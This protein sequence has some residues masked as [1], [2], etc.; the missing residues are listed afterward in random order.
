MEYLPQP[1]KIHIYLCKCILRIGFVVWRLKNLLIFPP[2]TFLHYHTKQTYT[3]RF[4]NQILLI[5]S[6]K[7][8]EI[9]FGL[10]YRMKMCW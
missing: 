8:H 2:K 9:I 7:V 3:P 1:T 5:C 6:V 4:G 10:Q